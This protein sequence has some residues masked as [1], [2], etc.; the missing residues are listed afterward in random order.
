MATIPIPSLS[1]ISEVTDDDLL[2][3]HELTSGLSGKLQVQIL[4]QFILLKYYQTPLGLFFQTGTT[5]TPTL[6]HRG[7]IIKLTN[8]TSI[9]LTIPSGVFS[10][11]HRLHFRQGGDG[12]VTFV[13]GSGVTLEVP[14]G[15]LPKIASKWH[16]VTAYLERIDGNEY[17]VLCGGLEGA[18]GGALMSIFTSEEY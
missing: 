5:F 15:G 4:K 6:S 16:L 8:A 7:A 2:V 17:W 18:S 10:V 9:T 13:A 11:G 3:L 1:S 12:Q 14:N